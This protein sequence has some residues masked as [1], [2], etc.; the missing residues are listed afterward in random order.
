MHHW[1]G[2]FQ[3]PQ[4]TEQ[5]VADLASRLPRISF[6][7]FQNYEDIGRAFF[8]A[9][10]DLLNVTPAIASLAEDIT[11]GKAG[12]REQAEA[13]SDWVTGNIRYLAVVIG[14]GRVVPNAPETVIANRYGDCKD[15]ATLMSALLAAKGI[16]SEYALIN[17]NPVYQL[18]ATP[19][20][21]SFNHVIVYLPEFDLYA[22]PTAAVSFVGRLPRADR[23]KPVLRVSKH[24]VTRAHTPIGTA[25]DNVASISS[26]LKIGVDEIVHGETAAWKDRANSH[27]CCGGSSCNPR[28]RARRL[29][30]MRL[31]S[32][33][34]L[35][36]NTYWKCRRQPAESSLTAS[37]RRG[38]PTSR[39]NWSPRG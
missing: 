18:D 12:R 31:A 10:E 26:R 4:S 32:N 38:R 6:S 2:R 35:S 16:A 14:V 24:Q 29:P 1:S 30:S 7:T 33:S 36:A 27:R 8:A 13:Y 23:G 39:S 17:T 28:A 21:G 22:D 37:R 9:A 25:D 15:V 11:R 19:L 3:I 34:T 5:N 20:V